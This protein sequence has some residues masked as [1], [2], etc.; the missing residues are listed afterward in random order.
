MPSTVIP[1]PEIL[2]PP[3]PRAKGWR[4]PL[5]ALA[6]IVHAGEVVHPLVPTGKE[7]PLS[8]LRRLVQSQLLLLLFFELNI[9]SRIWLTE[10]YSALILV[11]GITLIGALYGM[12][13]AI[14]SAIL[15]ALAFDYFISAPTFI[16][17]ISQVKHFAPPVIF[18]LAALVSGWLSG[19]L[20][21][22]TQRTMRSNRQLESLFAVSRD[23]QR[24]SGPEDVYRVMHATLLRQFPETG[25]RAMGVYRPD[26]GTMQPLGN[27]PALPMWLDLARQAL[28]GGRELARGGGISACLLD[29]GGGCNGVILVSDD[30]EPLDPAYLLALGRMVALALERIDLA[31]DLAEV[32]AKAR[33]DALRSSLLASVSHD[34]RTPLT[35][36]NTAASTLLSFGG[37]FDA[38]TSRGLLTDIVEEAERLNHLTTNLL[39]MTRL[40]SQDIGLR[41]ADLSVSEVVR[42]VVAHGGRLAPGRDIRFSLEGADMTV[43]VDTTLFDLA[44]TNVLHNA[45][46]YSQPPSSVDIACRRD[47]DDCVITIT[48]QGIGIPPAQIERVFD[49][50][51]RVQRED[52]GTRGSG[53]GLAIAKGFVEASGGAISAQSPVAD[54]HGTRMTIRLPL[55][56]IED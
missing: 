52:G 26:H 12:A 38:E 55:T 48:D 33:A 39:Q 47:G 34:L 50:F 21:D 28:A 36:I 51:Y 43:R 53:L 8:F 32:L 1:E 18:T 45:L 46:R 31:D 40:Q 23:L 35:V 16:F 30:P 17:T 41:M 13:L 3:T 24:A 10:G 37:T 11:L 27:S 2:I 54:G 49:R 19:R 20:R 29:T 25:G 4:A 42:R 22:Q 44:L 5:A 7:R 15:G 6:S 14:G 9:I 56:A